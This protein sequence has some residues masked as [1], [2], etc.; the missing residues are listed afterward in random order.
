[1]TLRPCQEN[2]KNTR[3]LI[4]RLAF[5]SGNTITNQA[6]RVCWLAGPVDREIH[7]RIACPDP[8]FILYGLWVKFPYKS[9]A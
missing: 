5:S 7:R 2:V 6:S 9:S 4:P 3:R 1:M 8:G